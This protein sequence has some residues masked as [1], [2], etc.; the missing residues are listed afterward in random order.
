VEWNSGTGI[1][2]V[3]LA[4]AATLALQANLTDTNGV[5]H[6]FNSPPRI[7]TNGMWQHI[8]LTYDRASGMAVLYRAGL[9]V[10]QTNLGSFVPR[11][12][13]DLFLGYRPVGVY[14]GSGTKYTGAMDE[15][16]IYSRALTPVEIRTIVK[17]RGEGK[18]LDG[19]VLV[20]FTQVE[21]QLNGRS[22]LHI[23][24][25]FPLDL[26]VEASTNLIHWQNIGV[27]QP[28]GGGEFELEDVESAGTPARYYRLVSP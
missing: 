4:T 10:A 1:Q 21:L 22:R 14:A 20:R 7:L 6:V 3:A 15:M 26:R 11:T 8:A 28:V 5:A 23:A 19:P 16:S 12:S 2:G 18:C 17:A 13:H 27:P 24:A 25:T 9:K